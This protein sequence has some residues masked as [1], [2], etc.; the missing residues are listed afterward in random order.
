MKISLSITFL[1][2]TAVV[3]SQSAVFSVPYRTAKFP[4]TNEGV[5]LHYTY[6]VT[7]KGKSPLI[8][9][10]SD[11]ECS[12]TDVQLPS[13]PILPGETKKIE[14]YFNTREKFFYQKRLITLTTNTRRK[15]ERLWLNVFVIP[16]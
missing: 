2:L 15:I 8:I 3:F 1:L 13:N 12:C 5:V 4:K 7:N 9:Y 16:N 11:T 10:A 6:L 14:V